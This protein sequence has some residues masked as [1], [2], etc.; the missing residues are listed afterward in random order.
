MKTQLLRFATC[1]G[2]VMVLSQCTMHRS[3]VYKAQ[4]ADL[5]SRVKEGQN[6]FDAEKRI[7][8]RYHYVTKPYDPTNLGKELC[9]NVDFGLQPTLMET[10]AY[11][12]DVKLPFDKNDS[13][14]AIVVS[15]ASGTIKS[16]E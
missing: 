14:S 7:R 1:L 3:S 8:G 13:I 12:A 10:L 5:R 6:I 9:M 15:D 4:M 2:S 16:I 11:T